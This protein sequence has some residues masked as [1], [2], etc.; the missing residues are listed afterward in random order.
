M[1]VKVFISSSCKIK[2]KT[3]NVRVKYLNSEN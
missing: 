3:D 2:Q 1:K